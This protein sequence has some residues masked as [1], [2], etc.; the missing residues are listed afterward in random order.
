MTLPIDEGG[1]GWDYQ[2]A[3]TPYTI[4][5]ICFSLGVF[6]GGRLQDKIGS[7][8]V[9]TIGGICVGLGLILAGLAGAN[10]F[11][12]AFCFGVISC[13]GIGFGYSS[14]LPTALK[15]FHPCQKG[16]VSGFVTGGFCLAAVYL[17]PM[18]TAFL[19][20]FSIEQSLMLLGTVS[21]ITSTLIA[22]FV[23]T[24]AINYMAANPRNFHETAAPIKVSVDF[25]SSEMV[26]TKRFYFMFFVFLINVSIGL[27]VIGNIASIAYYQAG[28]MDYRILAFLLAFMAIMNFFGRVGGGFVSDKIGRTNTLFVVM[29]VQMF[30][31][32]AFRSYDNLA[33]VMMG[34]LVA[35]T[36][37]GA[38]LSIFPAFTADQFGLKNHGAN[39]GVV[40]LAYGA[41]GVLAPFL[42]D[43]IYDNFNTYSYAYVV[44]AAMMFAAVF[45][46]F[47]LK[48]EVNRIEA[49]K[50]GNYQETKKLQAK[51]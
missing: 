43:Y 11:A 28:V 45:V 30:N 27:M 3:G 21:L 38:V 33:L 12:V 16:L 35:G 8:W 50:L 32:I 49:Q 34:A 37:F 40:Y 7:R 46:N 23:K 5:I 24:P 42:A 4:G 29:I 6:T 20:R 2:Q 51:L 14:V 1:W 26:R 48:R 10:T 17:A 25:T 47:A 39:Y 19:N 18:A 13:I 36:C 41:S 9:C 15:W 31:M 22:Q 44:C